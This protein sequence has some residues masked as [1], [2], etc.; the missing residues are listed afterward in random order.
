[1]SP[2]EVA[3]KRGIKRQRVQEYCTEGRIDGVIKMSRV[4]LIPKML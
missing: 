1:M 4:W 2:N 3:E